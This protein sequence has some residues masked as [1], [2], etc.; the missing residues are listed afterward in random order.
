MIS[1]EATGLTQGG[2]EEGYVAPEVMAA[3]LRAI[4][5]YSCSTWQEAV[6][7]A[8]QVWLCVCGVGGVCVLGG[9]WEGFWGVGGNFK[10]WVATGGVYDCGGGR[11]W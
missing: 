8:Q 4:S 9:G 1:T 2:F 10:F 6:K 7:V 11:V 5:G 3:H